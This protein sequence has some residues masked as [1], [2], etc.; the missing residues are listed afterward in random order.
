ML[1]SPSKSKLSFSI[2][3]AIDSSLG[4][5]KNGKIPWKFKNDMDFFKRKTIWCKDPMK[6]NVVI[7]GKNTWESLPKR[8][9]SD[10]K[11]IVISQS[12][13]N[14]KYKHWIEKCF[15]VKIYK[16]LDEA[17]NDLT[18]DY[19]KS[20]EQV[21]VIGG[22]PLYKE[23]IVHPQC[24]ELYLT[25]IPGTYD[26]DTFFPNIPKNFSELIT[27]TSTQIMPI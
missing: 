6:K 22:G 7:M 16:K 1:A 19:G 18:D 20:I 23:A 17:I 26:C 5:G 8:P 14:D 3:A 11:N 27:K 10:R 12:M 13:L 21:F 2:I 15:E 24:S 25:K 9:L 4:I